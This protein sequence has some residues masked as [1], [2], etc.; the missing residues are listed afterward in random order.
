MTSTP[1]FFIWEFPTPHPQGQQSNHCYSPFSF[2]KMSQK[3]HSNPT[4]QEIKTIIIK[5]D[6][7]SQT[8][9]VLLYRI[10]TGKSLCQTQNLHFISQWS[11]Y[12][13]PPSCITINSVIQDSQSSE[14]N[15]SHGV[16]VSLPKP[17]SLKKTK[18]TVIRPTCIKWL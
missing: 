5:N 17:F 15:L 11:A 13:I 14:S 12:L 16:E 8:H 3:E 10:S 1:I 6:R 2:Q 9:W 18:T 7:R 4:K